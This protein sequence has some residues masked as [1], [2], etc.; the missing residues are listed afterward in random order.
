MCAA[1]SLTTHA[2]TVTA[3]IATGASPEQVAVNPNTN[4]IYVTNQGSNTVT[5]ID[6]LTNNTTNVGVG[7]YPICLLYTSRCV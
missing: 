1:L 4:K 7:A 5:V 2:Q 3:T 6:G